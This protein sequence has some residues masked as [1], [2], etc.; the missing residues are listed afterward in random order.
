MNAPPTEP[1]STITENLD[2]QRAAIA[3]LG[4]ELR[5]LVEATVRTAAPA[6]TLHRMTDDGQHLK[7]VRARDI[8]E[9]QS[10][11][12]GLRSERI[13]PRTPSATR[14]RRSTC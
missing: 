3:A 5:A 8:S 12:V 10:A 7:V 14:A 9:G 1:P 11:T 13:T 4:H 6:E 2:H